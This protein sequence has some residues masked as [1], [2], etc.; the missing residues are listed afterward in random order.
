MWQKI[1]DNAEDYRAATVVTSIDYSKAFN[2]MGYQE[3]LKALARNGASTQ[4]LELVATFL[5]DRQMAVKVGSIM[6]EPRPVNGGCPQGSILGVFL[7]NAT[8]DDLEEGCN[9][10]PDTRM[11]LRREDR[12]VPSTPLKENSLP[13]EMP[14]ASPIIRPPRRAKR[15]NYTNELQE[16][17]PPEPNHWTEAK[18]EAAL[19]I[20]LR[21]IDDGFCLSK[22]NF[23]NSIGFNINGK[24]QRIKHAVQAQNIFRHVVR[25]AEEIG[26]V[27]NSSKTAMLC[28]SGAL[29]Y[30][31]DAY[32]L[33]ADQNRIG[34]NKTIKALGVRFSSKLNMDEQVDYIVR[35]MRSRYWTLRNLKNN[36][37]NTAE[38]IQVYKTV[39]RPLAEYG[40][41][42]FHS[43]LTDEQDERLELSLIHI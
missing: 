32:L 3:C 42:A 36:S 27:V 28:M 25:R 22:V 34:C 5:T 17:V 10:I 14:D 20:F 16:E 26:M 18:W 21:F 33:D 37:F 9:E 11:A 35:A 7:F 29:E 30:E 24:L 2:R 12:V 39:I 41:V 31:A 1:L 40:C 4:V 15:L 6:S 43:S 19:A 23:E 8:I 13:V 38:L